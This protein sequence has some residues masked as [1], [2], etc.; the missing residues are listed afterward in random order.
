MGLIHRLG[1]T[2]RHQTAEEE[3]ESDEREAHQ[4][5]QFRAL[6]IGPS[7]SV[8]HDFTLIVACCVSVSRERIAV[9]VGVC[10]FSLVRHAIC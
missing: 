3:N 8:N 4:N 1:L 5:M 6:N 7:F 10:V 2:P 9:V